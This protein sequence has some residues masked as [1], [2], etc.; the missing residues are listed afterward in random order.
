MS[1]ISTF[2]ALS[3]HSKRCKPDLPANDLG[4]RRAAIHGTTVVNRYTAKIT[5]CTMPCSTVVRPVPSDS[6][7]TSSDRINST[8]DFG[9]MPRVKVQPVA[10]ETIATAGQFSAQADAAGAAPRSPLLAAGMGTSI[11]IY[12]IAGYA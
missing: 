2:P 12:F 3:A 5:R 6:V 4:R 9:S 1:K 8:V 10:S 7:A 11:A